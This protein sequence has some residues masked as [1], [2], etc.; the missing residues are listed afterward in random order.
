MFDVVIVQRAHHSPSSLNTCCDT[1]LLAF[2][3]RTCNGMSM[4]G[5]RGLA[6]AIMTLNVRSALC[7]WS[8]IRKPAAPDAAVRHEGAITG[9]H[10]LSEHSFV[11]CSMDGRL[12]VWDI[13]SGKRPVSILHSPDNR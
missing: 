1:L 2:H 9:L 7:R 5:R 11:S 10:S 8:M 4:P 12:C 13:K 3:M 6:A